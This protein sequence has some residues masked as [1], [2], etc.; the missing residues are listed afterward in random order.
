MVP[1]RKFMDMFPE[2][3]WYADWKNVR[4][5]RGYTTVEDEYQDRDFRF[6]ELYPMVTQ[7]HQR[8]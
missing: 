8:P 5:S 2:H 7:M 4:N 3:K 6:T 1:S